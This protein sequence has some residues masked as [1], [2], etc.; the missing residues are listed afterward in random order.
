MELQERKL[1]YESKTI[2]RIWLIL[3][4]LSSLKNVTCSMYDPPRERYLSLACKYLRLAHKWLAL[5]IRNKGRGLSPLLCILNNCCAVLCF[6]C[7]WL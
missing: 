6:F 7:V 5:S 4:I 3:I 1:R 2:T